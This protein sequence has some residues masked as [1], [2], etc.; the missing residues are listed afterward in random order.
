[1]TFQPAVSS[2]ALKVNQQSR[3]HDRRCGSVEEFGSL[4]ARLPVNEQFLDNL[5]YYTY[6]YL[7]ILFYCWWNYLRKV[8]QESC[9]GLFSCVTVG[10]LTYSVC[11]CCSVVC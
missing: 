10:T 7:F 6:D 4:S 9:G 8:L 5:T 11:D 3:H 2:L 1:M